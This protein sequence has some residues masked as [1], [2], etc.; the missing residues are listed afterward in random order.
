LLFYRFLSDWAYPIRVRPVVD[1]YVRDEMKSDPAAMR[2]PGAAANLAKERLQPVADEIF[3]EQ[4]H[5]NV[6]AI[7]LSGGSRAIFEISLFQRFQTRFTSPKTSNPEFLISI[8]SPQVSSAESPNQPASAEWSLTQNQFDDRVQTRIESIDWTSFKT[9]AQTVEL[10]LKTATPSASS[11]GAA[12]SYRITGSH[13]RKNLKV[14]ITASTAQ[15]AFYALGKLE[16]LGATGGLIQDFQIVESPAFARRGVMES[17]DG[18]AWRSRDRLEMMKFLGR[19]RINQYIYAPRTDPFRTERW[20]EDYPEQ[21]LERI[22]QLAAAATENFVDVVYSIE[23]GPSLVFANDAE[24]AALLRKFNRLSSA[25]VRRFLID[26]EALPAGLQNE[27]DREKFKTLAAA[28]ANFLTRLY[29]KLKATGVGVEL[30]VLPTKSE[31][32]SGAKSETDYLK[33][34]A[35]AIPAELQVFWKC[36][37]ADSQNLT[38][39]RVKEWSAVAGRKPMI[40]D[41][42]PAN[43]PLKGR[44]VL[45]PKRGA[46]PGLN[47]AASGFTSIAGGGPRLSMLSLA[48]TAQYAWDPPKYD[49]A[50]AL[51]AAVALLYDQRAQA[52]VRSWVGAVEDANLFGPL[53]GAAKLEIAL[54]TRESKLDELQKSLESLIATRDQGLLRGDLAQILRS[55]RTRIAQIKTDP[56]FEKLPNGN[57]KER[58]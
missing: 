21:D 58:Q 27:Q 32:I 31:V 2:D 41:R 35:A 39:A 3:K 55:A 47:A 28:E 11:A 50:R 23:P 45:G 5:R 34:L 14:E 20:R 22:K 17:S 18:P 33:D 43:D 42:Y 49:P 10:S 12:E 53:L 44:L 26:F 7:L 24:I 4:F 52:A 56:A 13:K 46:S 25:G 19:V 6:H 8:H 40:L 57:Y 30:S 51:E 54:T 36:T 37:E 16:L 48:T 1:A 15:G 38:D 9:D 29:D